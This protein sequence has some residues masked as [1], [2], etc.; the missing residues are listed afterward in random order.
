M[1]S[2]V[3]SSKMRTLRRRAAVKKAAA[4]VSTKKIS[5]WR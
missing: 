2:P 3:T 4:V 5:P 1:S